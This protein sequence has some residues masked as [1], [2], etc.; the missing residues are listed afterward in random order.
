MGKPEGSKPR[1]MKPAL[2]SLFP[3][4][5]KVGNKRLMRDAAVRNESIDL[6]KRRNPIT[7][8]STWKKFIRSAD[9]GEIVETIFEENVR[10]N[11][12]YNNLWEEAL[13]AADVTG[14]PPVK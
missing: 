8:E 7:G 14:S 11:V 2:H 13:V 5:H 4:G 6:A 9:T 3:V 10:T 1:E 12:D